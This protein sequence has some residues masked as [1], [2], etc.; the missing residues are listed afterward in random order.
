MTADQLNTLLD[1]ALNREADLRRA[2]ESV[3][4][5]KTIDDV[6]DIASTALS[7]DEAHAGNARALFENQL[8]KP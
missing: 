5:A 7:A 6:R 3:R 1:Q 2:L 8:R 4:D